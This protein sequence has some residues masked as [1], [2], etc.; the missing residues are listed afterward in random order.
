MKFAHFHDN[1]NPQQ[2]VAL[3]A[4][5]FDC[6][7]PFGSGAAIRLKS[8]ETPILVHETPEEVERIVQESLEEQ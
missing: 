3:D 6:V 4:E 1:L 8:S 2:H 5:D 7:Y